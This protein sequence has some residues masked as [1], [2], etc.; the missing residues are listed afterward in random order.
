MQ[1]KE[2]YYNHKSP[3]SIFLPKSVHLVTHG[4]PNKINLMFSIPS[5]VYGTQ[6][7]TLFR[8][9]LCGSHCKILTIDPLLKNK[10]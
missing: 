9:Q 10:G 4:K 2:T 3:L 1:N 6:A 5:I 7:A 8:L